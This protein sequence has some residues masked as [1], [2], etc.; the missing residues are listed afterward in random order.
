LY[1]DNYEYTSHVNSIEGASERIK[2][3]IRWYGTKLKTNKASLEVKSKKGFYSWKVITKN[4]YSINQKAARWDSFYIHNGFTQNIYTANLNFLRPTSIVSYERS[5][6]SNY[7]RN[8]RVTLDR[9][10]VSFDQR[11]STRP[12]YFYKKNHNGLLILEVKSD[13]LKSVQ[14]MVDLK[15]SID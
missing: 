13:D 7:D 4:S 11:L 6:F 14:F 12:S 2:T 3:R 15:V 1:F 8:L 5:Y 10:L 9:N